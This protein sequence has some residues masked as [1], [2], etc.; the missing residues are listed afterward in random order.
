MLRSL[1]YLNLSFGQGDKYESIFI[2]LHVDIHLDQYHLLKT[3]SF[4]IVLFGFFIKNQISI[5]VWAYFWVFNSIPLITVSVS[6]PIP[7]SYLVVVVVIWLFCFYLFVCFYH[8]C[9]VV[10]L[11]LWDVNSS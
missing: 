10:Q 8:Y 11:D 2:L 6:V 4:S 3:L 9:S 5:R 7:Y 1:I